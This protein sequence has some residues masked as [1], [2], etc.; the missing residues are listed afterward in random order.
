[1]CIHIPVLLARYVRLPYVVWHPCHHGSPPNL[2]SRSTLI[3]TTVTVQL[4]LN[5]NI[6]WLYWRVEYEFTYF[7]SPGPLCSAATRCGAAMS[8]W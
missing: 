2:D 6:M 4:G 5:L 8:E 3:L 7:R 1:M